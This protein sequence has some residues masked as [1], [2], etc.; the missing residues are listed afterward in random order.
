MPNTWDPSSLDPDAALHRL[1]VGNQRFLDGTGTTHR[2]FG[3]P[4]HGPRLAS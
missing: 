1:K 3:Y 4:L 2:T